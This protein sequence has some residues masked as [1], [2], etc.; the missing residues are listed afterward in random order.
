MKGNFM[1]FK[2]TKEEYENILKVQEKT[3]Q[4]VKKILI[5]VLIQDLSGSVSCN[6]SKGITGF[7]PV[8]KGTP[9]SINCVL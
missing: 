9:N 3:G 2:L 8:Q 7:L 5:D 1:G 4:N 6:I